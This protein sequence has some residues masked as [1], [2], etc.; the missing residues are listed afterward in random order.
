[1]EQTKVLQEQDRIFNATFK[2]FRDNEVLLKSAK[3]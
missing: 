1:M 2:Q 3:I